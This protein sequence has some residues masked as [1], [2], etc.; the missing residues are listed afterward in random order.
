MFSWFRKQKP[1]EDAKI[2]PTAQ[3]ADSKLAATQ[4]VRGKIAF[5]NGERTWTEQFDVV[6]I[7]AKAACRQTAG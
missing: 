2:A 1:A 5:A 7:A 4:L 6:E 3:A